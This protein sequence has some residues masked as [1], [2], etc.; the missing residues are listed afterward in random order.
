MREPNCLDGPFELIDLDMVEYMA[1]QM[2]ISRK[3]F[4]PP[5]DPRAGTRLLG[6]LEHMRKEMIEV[7]DAPRDPLEWADLIILAMDGA[8]RQGITPGQLAF[9]L[10]AKQ[11]SNRSR[12]WPDWRN[13]RPDQPIEHDRSG[14]DRPV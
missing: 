4:G 1:A 9:A 8:W 10:V 3:A 6:I 11:M 2:V 13:A 14:D 12:R 5:E 7:I